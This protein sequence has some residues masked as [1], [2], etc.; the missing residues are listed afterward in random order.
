MTQAMNTAFKVLA[1][2]LLL[3][4][5]LAQAGL[6]GKGEGKG[7]EQTLEPNV[8]I[9]LPK[10]L[11]LQRYPMPIPGASNYRIN[12]SGM[13]IAITGIPTDLG[14]ES[15]PQSSDEALKAST[16]RGAAQ[17]VSDAANP[18]AVPVQVKGAGWTL[19]HVSYTAKPGSAGFVPFMGAAYRCVSSGSL[20]TE[21]TVFVITVGSPDCASG[22]HQAFLK[23]LEAVKLAG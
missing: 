15:A 13:R 16:L 8:L 12:T 22:D 20:H 6:F 7:A 19:T 4:P 14:G 5:A 11:K 1:S 10:A 23:A 18:D 3:L 17:Y 21:R 2:A 9:V